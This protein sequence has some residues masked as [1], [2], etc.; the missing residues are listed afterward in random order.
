LALV[1]MVPDKLEGEM[2]DLQ[3]GLAFLKNVKISANTGT[4]MIFPPAI[5]HHT[6]SLQTTPLPPAR[7]FAS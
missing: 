5:N 3:H 7:E 1:D 2:M 6:I 4:N